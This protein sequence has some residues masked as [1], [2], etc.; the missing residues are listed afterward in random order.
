[1][2]PNRLETSEVQNLINE[3]YKVPSEIPVNDA[4]FYTVLAINRT[5][6]QRTGKTTLECK[7]ITKDP[8]DWANLQNYKDTALMFGAQKI[9]LLHD[10]F[11][12]TEE[13]PKRGR[14]PKTEEK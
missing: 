6:N 7:A 9:V 5:T 10:P 11:T 13:K 2:T 4:K 3:G 12:K 1:M 14:K 8:V